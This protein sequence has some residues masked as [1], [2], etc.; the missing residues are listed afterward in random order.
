MSSVRI[1]KKHSFRKYMKYNMR[2]DACNILAKRM[3]GF[4]FPINR[5]NILRATHNLS[6]KRLGKYSNNWV[7]LQ[8]LATHMLSAKH[9]LPT[10]ANENKSKYN[11]TITEL[12]SNTSE[13]MKIDMKR[14][15]KKEFMF[16]KNIDK[17]KGGEHIEYPSSLIINFS[18]HT[19]VARGHRLTNESSLV[20]IQD[21]VDGSVYMETVHDRNKRY[22]GAF[23]APESLYEDKTCIMR[24]DV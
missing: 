5:K 18:D 14:K 13:L 21:P 15:M 11:D 7:R 9:L 8:I 4:G 22:E 1:R 23:V 12:K 2:I 20:N 17:I 3:K 10:N 6:W 24:K 19:A 16:D